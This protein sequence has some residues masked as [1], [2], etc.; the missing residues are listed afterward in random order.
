MVV[1]EFLMGWHKNLGGERERERVRESKG[2]KKWSWM[3]NRHESW[4]TRRLIG[5]ATQRP[6]KRHPERLYLVAKQPY[7]RCLNSVGI[8]HARQHVF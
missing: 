2:G 7:T 4:I 1:L 5:S 3:S 8:I 6:F